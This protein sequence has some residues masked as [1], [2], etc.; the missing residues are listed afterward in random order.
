M[1]PIRKGQSWTMPT[2]PIPLPNN[3]DVVWLQEHATRKID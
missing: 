3:R 1:P 2:G